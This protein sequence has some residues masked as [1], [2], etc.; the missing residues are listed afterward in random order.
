MHRPMPNS[1]HKTP[2][3]P[4]PRGHPG[5]H[6]NGEPS[7]SNGPHGPIRFLIIQRWMEKTTGPQRGGALRQPGCSSVIKFNA[8]CVSFLMFSR[9]KS[10]SAGGFGHHVLFALLHLLPSKL[11]CVKFNHRRPPSTRT[12]TPR[13]AHAAPPSA[14]LGGATGLPKCATALGP[15]VFFIHL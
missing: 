4:N 13:T 12:S 8:Y 2:L 14:T 15:V 7:L 9:K 5:P 10:P 11:I 3:Q 6:P 1:L